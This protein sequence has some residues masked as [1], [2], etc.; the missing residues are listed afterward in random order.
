MRRQIAELTSKLETIDELT[1][2]VVLAKREESDEYKSVRECEQKERDGEMER[3]RLRRLV[4]L[5][6]Q[7]EKNTNSSL[8]KHEI[9]AEIKEEFL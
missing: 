3:R 4:E 1:E 6:N 5:L 7:G 8:I 2:Q 9:K